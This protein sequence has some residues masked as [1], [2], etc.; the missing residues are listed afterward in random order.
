MAIDP[1]GGHP[2]MDYPEHMRT[3]SGFLRATVV[4]IVFVVLDP[5]V[6]V[7]ARALGRTAVHHRMRPA[8]SRACQPR[9]STMVTIAVTAERDG[10]PRVAVSPETVKKLTALGCHGE[11]AGGSRRRAR[12]SPTTLLK[13]QGAA[14]AASAAEALAGADILLKVRRP[15]PDE[16]QGAEARRHRRRH[17]GALRRPRRASRRWPA[18]A[19]R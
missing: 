14:I 15:S 10:E 9:G 8:R 16:V 19:R 11:G 7:V 5:A 2:A 13:A 3:Y 18:P 1:S 6:P 4:M 12:A 17:A